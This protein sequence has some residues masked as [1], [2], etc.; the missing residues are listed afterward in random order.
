MEKR[1]KKEYVKPEAR[2]HKA[3]AVVSGTDK[4]DI[5]C[6]MYRPAVASGGSYWY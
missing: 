6:H 2:K 3:V 1:P 4:S 5:T